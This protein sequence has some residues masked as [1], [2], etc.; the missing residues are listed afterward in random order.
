M[1]GGVGDGAEPLVDLL[2]GQAELVE[3][4]G[5]RGG[6]LAVAR[7]AAG[8]R[9][10]GERSDRVG[11]GAG[12]L[13]AEP[14]VDPL[15]GADRVVHQVVVPDV[16]EPGLVAGRPLGREPLKPGRPQVELVAP[17]HAAGEH[18][19]PARRRL[20]G[21]AADRR[22]RGPRRAVGLD[23]EGVGVDLEQRAEREQVA[24]VLQHP[25]LVRVVQADQLQVPAVPPVRRGP[26]LVAQPGRVARQVREA[27]ERD[28]AHR[29]PQQLPALLDLVGGDVVHAHELGVLDVVARVALL[30]ELVDRVL[31]PGGAGRARLRHL[32]QPHLHPLGGRVGREQPVQRGGAGPGQAGDEDRRLDRDRRVLRVRPPACLARQPGGQR[33]AQHRPLRLRAER[34]EGGV[35]GARVEQHRQPVGVVVGAEVGQAGA[36][37]RG[38]VQVLDGADPVGAVRLRAGQWWYSP[39]LTSRHWPVIARAMS[40]ARNTAASAISSGS[41][42]RPRSIGAAVSA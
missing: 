39:Q 8:R 36:P 33:P 12:Q 24:R 13:E 16:V 14:G 25:P 35:A 10:G 2:P 28:R 38:R 18:R 42:S 6:G 37:G 17:E 31:I 41:G 26:V 20:R 3:R 40:L 22:D 19:G 7:G 29:L 4:V 9:P 23:D 34:G 11:G 5:V 27:L 1:S 15:D 30:N 32:G 21:Q